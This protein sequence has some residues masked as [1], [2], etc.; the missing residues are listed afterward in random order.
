MLITG[1]TR[2]HGVTEPLRVR[3]TPL[4][5]RLLDHCP[6]PSVSARRTSHSMPSPH[7]S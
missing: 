4:K 7:H 3:L 5:I 6:V 1:D 2:R